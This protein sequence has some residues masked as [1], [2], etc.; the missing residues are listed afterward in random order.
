MEAKRKRIFTRG[1][2]IATSSCNAYCGAHK[3]ELQ[4]NHD[5][6]IEYLNSIK[7]KKDYKSSVVFFANEVKCPYKEVKVF[8]EWKP[9]DETLIEVYKRQGFPM[10]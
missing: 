8:G 10:R 7:P 3:E 9:I 4:R 6:N 5:E 1:G 2:M